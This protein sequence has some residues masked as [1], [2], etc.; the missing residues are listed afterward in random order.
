VSRKR[1]RLP[2]PGASCYA[3]TMFANVEGFVIC[4]LAHMVHACRL[5]VGSPEWEELLAGQPL[6]LGKINDKWLED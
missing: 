5:E 1:I 3:D 2:A 4:G 6:V